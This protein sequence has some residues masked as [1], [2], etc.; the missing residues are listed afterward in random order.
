MQQQLESIVSEVKAAVASIKTR[1][2]FEVFKAKISG[3]NGLLTAVKKTIGKLPQAEKPAAGKL[4]NRAKQQVEEVFAEILA[5]IEKSELAAKLGEPID[6]TLPSPDDFAGMRHPLSQIRE[7]MCGIFHRLGFTVA[8][9]P[10]LETEWFCF[11]ALNTP[12]NHP[13]RDMQDTLFF[14]ADTIAADAPKHADEAYLLRSHTSSVQIRAML[15]TKPPLR[16]VAPG[17]CFRRDTVDATHSANFHQIEGLWVDENVTLRDLKSVLDFFV[18][19]VFGHA[20]ETRLRP[21][22]FPF[23]EPSFEMDIRVPNLGAL[24]NRWLEIMGCGLVDPKVFEN[25]GIDPEKWSGLAFG[26]GIERIAMLVHG[27]DDIR[28]FY[29]NDLRFLRQFA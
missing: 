16:V 29:A 15:A 17:R 24:S 12:A 8:E 26:I 6:P 2:E 3:S 19:E 4:I 14:P 1:P 20:A 11:D 23:T 7:E 25:V 9:G 5:R 22:F 27:I 21:S 28:H 13:A 18:R 10:E